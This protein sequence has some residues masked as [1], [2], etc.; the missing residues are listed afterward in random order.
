MDK[1]ILKSSKAICLLAL[2]PWGLWAL[3][4]ILRLMRFAELINFNVYLGID[5]API[6]WY[7]DEAIIAQYIELTG[8]VITNIMMIGMVFLFI[9]KSLKGMDVNEVFSRGNVMLLYGM[10]AVSF[11]YELFTSNRGILYG[12]RE[13]VL[14]T[15]PF[16]TPLILLVV[17]VF[18][19]LALHAYE[20]NRLTI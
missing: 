5:I 20:E 12:S 1:K 9:Y 6:A 18:Y 19:R 2:I 15:A 14:D 3:I 7:D 10:A 16:T 11:F 8:Y 13:L 17:A 4:I